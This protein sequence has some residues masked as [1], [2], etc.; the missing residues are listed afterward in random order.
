LDYYDPMLRFNRIAILV[1]FTCA[2]GVSAQNLPTA[3]QAPSGAQLDG[4]LFY[5]L[6]VGEINARGG[7]AGAA[8]SLILD[9]A[10]KTRSAQLFQRAVEIGLQARS[11]PSA[12]QAAQAWKQV[13]PE[14]KEANGFLFQIL[15]GLN[16]TG[17]TL[18]PLKQEMAS[19]PALD[20]PTF[21]AAIPQYYARTS[22]KQLAAD[23][24]EKALATHMTIP[25]EASASWSTIA[26]MR[27]DAA[28]LDGAIDA[29]RKAQAA[30]PTAEGPALLSIYLM[31]EK[32]P[33]AE[34]LI[35]QTLEK[36][37]TPAI[38]MEYARTLLNV[39]RYSEAQAQLQIITTTHPDFKD[40]WLVQGVLQAQESNLDAAEKSLQQY[41]ALVTPRQKDEVG[42][43]RGLTQAYLSLAQIAEQRQNYEAADAWLSR[44]D[45]KD[46]VLSAQ[47]RR[48]VLMAKQGKV[49]AAL[50]LI[51]GQSANSDSDARM[52]TATEVQILREEKQYAAAY[53]VLK[54]AI[55]RTPNDWDFVYDMAMVVE[56]M[57]NSAEMERL[58]RSIIAGKPD[59]HHAYNALG[60]ALADRGIQLSEA[61]QL[62]LKAL[63][64]AKEDPFIM[65][66]LGWVE[67]RSGNHDEAMR[68]LQSAFNLKPDPEIAAHLGEVMWTANRRE[69][70][71][72]VWKQGAQLN[73]KNETL[74]ET[75]KRLG[76]KW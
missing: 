57:G 20:R 71:V 12:L 60:Y 2:L 53:A 4:P 32:V 11:G 65:D 9:A 13:L 75:L 27:F 45:S 51:H 55:D 22:D 36:H 19:T 37:P 44:I 50:Q 7:D 28:D 62:I 8:Y 61:K 24:V 59:Y 67:F 64:F 70:A 73:P 41:I 21:I 35:L 58:L 68:I 26:R 29:T 34:A 39:Q 31:R 63:E 15:I 49:D 16:R 69:E 42:D 30:E 47:L 10:R 38:R 33:N 66:S 40:S 72:L 74:L 1:S 5:Q 14:S 46:N 56:K 52:K 17:E 18:E 3:S 48:A 23:T 43:D 6:L 54:T 25:A 76:V